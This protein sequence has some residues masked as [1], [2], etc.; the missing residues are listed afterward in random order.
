MPAGNAPRGSLFLIFDELMSSS[1]ATNVVQKPYN[2]KLI[3]QQ[4]REQVAVGEVVATARAIALVPEVSD[5]AHVAEAMAA[6]GEER[7]LD[8]LHANRA[9]E[10]L[11][12]LRHRDRKRSVSG[13][14]SGGGFCDGERFRWLGSHG[15]D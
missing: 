2:N 12:R 7:V 9:Q 10:V 13:D 5:D 1:V 14:D 4:V 6:G 15:G 3:E 11:I 8:D